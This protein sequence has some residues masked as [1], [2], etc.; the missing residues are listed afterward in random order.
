M[1]LAESDMGTY[2]MTP[3]SEMNIKVFAF[4]LGYIWSHK[5]AKLFSSKLCQ[6]CTIFDNL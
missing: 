3:R 2:E 6:I 5:C 4:S 1:A